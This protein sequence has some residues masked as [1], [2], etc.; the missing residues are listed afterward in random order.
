LDHCRLDTRCVAAANLD[1]ANWSEV[2]RVGVEQPVLQLLADHS[3]LQLPCQNQ[4]DAGVY[5]SA[6]WCEAERA[7]MRDGWQTVHERARPGYCALIAGTGHASF[8]D[9]GFL[10][11]A[12][13]SRAA[14]GLASV[15]VEPLRA[16]RITCDFLL[17]FFRQHLLGKDGP[18]PDGLAATYPDARVGAPQD[19]LA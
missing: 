19:V 18:L 2:G 7:L 16:W 15:Q 1:G 17:A 3:E 10:L 12:D 14:G 4:V 6:A 11:L 9:L 5:P 13:Q 8:L